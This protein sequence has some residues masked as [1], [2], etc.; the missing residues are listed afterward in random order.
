M[1]SVK[2]EQTVSQLFYQTDLEFCPEALLGLILSFVI[3][4]NIPQ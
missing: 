4:E 3:D 1:T 2:K